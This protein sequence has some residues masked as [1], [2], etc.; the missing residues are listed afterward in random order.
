MK[1]NSI[2]IGAGASGGHI[3]PAVSIANILKEKDLHPVI[4]TTR[5][6]LDKKIVGEID[7]FQIES[8]SPSVSPLKLLKFLRKTG[9][10]VKQAKK[11]LTKFEPKVVLG[12]GG[13]PSV[14]LV[15][16]ARKKYPILLHESNFVAGRANSFLAK[17]ADV[18]MTGFPGMTNVPKN[19]IEVV[20]NPI[21]W[22]TIPARST[23]IYKLFGLD[24]NKKTVVIMGGSQ[25][26]RF[27]NHAILNL[28]EILLA[29][30]QLQWLIISGKKQFADV[31]SMVCKKHLKNIFVRDYV[32]EMDKL[33]AVTDIA[34]TRGGAMTAS[35]IE[36]YGIPAV[37]IPIKNSIYN[38]QYKNGMYLKSKRDNVI[39]IDEDD[40]FEGLGQSIEILMSAEKTP[41]AKSS[42]TEAL[43]A[44]VSIIENLARS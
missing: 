19:K 18:I 21:R 11:L 35:E 36:T 12:M 3:L 16:A 13:Y 44:I 25:G 15:Y 1:K 38:H 5:K 10:G 28:P 6:T 17:Y 9:K 4:I 34:V 41:D 33:Y 29:N 24:E 31:D 39:V 7:S 30:S 22:N 26:A 27:V 40:V 42:H 2:L 23:E 8:A 14:P 20:G 37:I 43:D 32:D